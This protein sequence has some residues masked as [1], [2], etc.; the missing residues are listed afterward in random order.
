MGAAFYCFCHT[1]YKPMDEVKHQDFDRA[2]RPSLYVVA[3]PIGNL[4]DLSPRARAML[5]QV[6][7][8][9][10][11]DT[12]NTGLLLEKL[13][14]KKPLMATH[15]HNERDSAAGIV[16]CLQRGES[17]ALVSDAG[18][19]AVSDPGVYVVRAVVQAGFPVVPIPGA[20][21]VV[22]AVSIS[23]IVHGPFAFQGFLPSKSKAR[24]EV[25]ANLLE[26]ES[27]QVFFEAPHRI[28][29]FMNDLAQC[30]PERAVCACRELTKQYE[31]FYRGSAS[32]VQQQVLHDVNATRGEWVVVV[33]G[34]DELESKV[35]FGTIHEELT[36]LLDLVP[37]KALANLLGKLTG[38]G[39][40]EAYQQLLEMKKNQP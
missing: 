23:G 5:S 18:T 13:G 32:E 1:R 8:I 34:K 22:T 20:S 17:V 37:T 29:D 30:A 39:K 38:V 12:R 33:A 31:S 27:P 11:E 40:K 7:R 3:T 24:L 25:M 35:D 28:V 21:S 4:G 2:E 15:N 9:A 26:S 19:P 36:P 14:I 16:Q 10:A 6:D